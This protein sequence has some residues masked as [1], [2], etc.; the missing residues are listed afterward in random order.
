MPEKKTNGE[1][2]TQGADAAPESGKITRT[3]AVRRA[4]EAKGPEV[5][6]KD[7]RAYVLEHFGF[8][9]S[10]DHISNCKGELGKR[11]AA[12]K[13]A[14][15]PRRGRRKAADSTRLPEAPAA[16]AAPEA[17]ATAEPTAVPALTAETS[18]GRS[19]EL[20]QLKDDV[21]MVKELV[22]RIGA[23][24]LRQLISAFEK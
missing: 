16:D 1:G 20:K 13:A 9:M 15:K 22:D 2:A 21:L 4:L 14:A 7:I 19:R 17:V 24:Y 12:E 3:E 11:E 10:L 5:S 23:D 8:E 18:N 6:R